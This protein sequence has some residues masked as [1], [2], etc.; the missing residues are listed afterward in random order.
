MFKDYV[1]TASEVRAAVRKNKPAKK[2]AESRGIDINSYN[3][4]YAHEF[5]ATK[6][7]KDPFVKMRLVSELLWYRNRRPF[8]NVY[9]VI[10]KKLLE[11]D[12]P[13]RLDELFL[14]SPTIEI[15]TT[16]CTFLL[17]DAGAA[18]GFV[19][20]LEKGR[21][22]EFMMHKQG[23]VNEIPGCEYRHIH[24]DWPEKIAA[25]AG[26]PP[27]N[28]EQRTQIALLACGVCLLAKDPS[29]VVPVVLNKHRKDDMTPDELEI[30][31][32][33]AI[34]ATDKTGWDVG[35]D[36]QFR[37]AS[38]HY[39]NGCFAKYYVTKSHHQYP[40]NCALQRA[41][42]IKWRSGA[43]VNANNTPTVPTGFK[44]AVESNAN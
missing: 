23:F 1:S 22:A 36:M 4:I 27:L 6:H 14:P 43:V 28:E 42:I 35:R 10:E 25:A 9:P 18:F 26:T 29:I 2:L 30:Y 13:L 11:I 15:R 3:S 34:D 41:P 21:Y 33:K 32:Q 16:S 20:E 17:N 8:F 24:S 7:L 31:K 39:R 37:Q 12:A 19:V 40:E 38:C 5:N 44:D